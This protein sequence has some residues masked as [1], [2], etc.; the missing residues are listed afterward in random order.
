MP[1][2]RF[3]RFAERRG[4]D[5]ASVVSLEGRMFPV[6]V[7]YLKEACVDYTEAAI[8]TVFSIHMK[9]STAYIPI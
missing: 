7:C 8:Q 3:T 9:V 2:V 5:N 1:S 4:A 6:E